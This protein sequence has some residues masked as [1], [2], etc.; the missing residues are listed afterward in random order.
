MFATL[1]SV[2]HC[3][4]SVEEIIGQEYKG[5]DVNSHSAQ[6]G[7]Q[8][9][10]I[11]PECFS[12]KKSIDSNCSACGIQVEI[13][14]GILVQLSTRDKNNELLKDY[15]QIYD[16][17]ALDDLEKSIQHPEYLDI[18][19]KKLF[20]YLPKRLG[21]SICEVGVGQGRI[22]K[23]LLSLSPSKLVGVD[24]AVPYLQKLT[25]EK[26]PFEP[27]IAN[28]ENLPF[29]NEFDLLI[30]TDVLEHVL[31]VGNYLYSINQSLKLGGVLAIRTPYLEDYTIYSRFHE[32]P[33]DLVH[34]RNFS[35]KTL[36]I[37]LEG[38][39][40]KV[41]QVHF[42][43]FQDHNIRLSGN[44]FF[45]KMVRKSLYSIY[46]NYLNLPKIPN[47]IGKIFIK[48]CEITAIC[49]KVRTAP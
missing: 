35:R 12:E 21:L 11:C 22:I 9:M 20:S 13:L 44:Y 40:F 31:N 46:E 37:I 34:L 5:E 14:E 19:A 36:K 39:G 33:Y 8:D 16:S 29:K 25:R 27:I 23:K 24:I 6:P 28:A 2:F 26:V 42:D 18:Q 10:L 49:E 1:S 47:W 32:C 17:V 43:G 7:S 38:V 15:R 4:Y 48:P 41:N 3:E 45:G 30:S